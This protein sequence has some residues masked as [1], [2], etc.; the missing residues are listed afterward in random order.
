[1]SQSNLSGISVL[2]NDATSRVIGVDD[3]L[4]GPVEVEAEQITAES[5]DDDVPIATT[6]IARPKKT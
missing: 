5:D 3:I 6:L 1:M 2:D 4:L